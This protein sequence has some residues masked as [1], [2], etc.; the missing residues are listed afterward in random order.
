MTK[1]LINNADN[2][3]ARLLLA[4]GAGAGANS[5]V[6]QQ[7]ALALA[8]CGIEVWRFNFGY[9]QQALDEGRRRL[10]AKMPLLAA[11]FNQQIAQCPSDLPLFI[12][13]KSM[14]GRVAS[15]LSGQSAVQAVFAFGYPFHAPN[16]PQWRT[17]HFADL[18]APLYIA[19]GER[20]AF[21][22][23]DELSAKHWPKVEL[24]WLTDA[25]HDFVPRVKSGFTQLQLIS[26]AAAFCSRKIDEVLLAAK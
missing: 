1:I 13:G 9:M 18:T 2:A 10:P 4:H 14:G 7:L 21:G 6:M 24:Y 17:E 25:N 22:S 15:L 5:D 12:G 20:D 16:K 3:K 11:E 19:Q 8:S 26:A 23:K